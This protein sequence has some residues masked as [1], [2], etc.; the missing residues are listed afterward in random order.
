[1]LFNDVLLSC[2]KF[3]LMDSLQLRNVLAVTTSCYEF[4]ETIT[5]QKDLIKLIF[6]TLQ[7]AIFLPE[8]IGHENNNRN[9]KMIGNNG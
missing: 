9:T 5:N 3:S 6:K 1:M 2:G 8:N 4:C 7:Q